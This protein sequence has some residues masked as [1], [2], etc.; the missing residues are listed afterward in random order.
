MPHTGAAL[1]S[2]QVLLPQAGQ[3]VAVIAA[4]LP[5]RRARLM[6]SFDGLSTS[7]TPERVK[8]GSALLTIWSHSSAEAMGAR[9]AL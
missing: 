6:P 4:R 7:T 2:G 1:C 3:D 5:E 8:R 9:D